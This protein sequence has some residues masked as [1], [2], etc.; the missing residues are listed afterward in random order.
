[1]RQAEWELL[2]LAVSLFCQ[3]KIKIEGKIA[4]IVE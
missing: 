1:M 2:P 4:T 3:G